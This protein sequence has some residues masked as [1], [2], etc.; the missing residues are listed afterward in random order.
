LLA[1]GCESGTV[2]FWPKDELA[3]IRSG[4]G[5]PEVFQA[6]QGQITALA[7]GGALLA[8]AGTDH[9][10]SLWDVTSVAAKHTLAAGGVTRA[11]ALSA[12]GKI[13]ATA[14]DEL[15][16]TLWDTVTGQAIGKLEGH[17]DW[18]LAMA[19]TAEGG[20]LLSG[21]Y[22]GVVR[23]W[24]VA[25]RKK[26][27]DGTVTAPPAP[28]TPPSAPVP[29]HAL[30]LSQDG[31]TLAVGCFDARIHLVN[32]A[33]GKLARSLGGHASAVTGLA[34]I[35]DFLVTGS[36]DATVRVWSLASGQVVKSLDGNAAWVLGVAAAGNSAVSIGADRAVRVWP[37][38]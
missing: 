27:L 15:A 30:A 8:T 1:V 28:N 18:V 4:S 19:F 5:S 26:I 22:D 7:W 36:R 34:F 20:R 9:K 6:H 24:D 13:L 17:T 11:L 33:D 25:A 35:D 37:F 3:G 10:V 16:I 29:I 2:Y 23:I 14:G 21:G 32:P 31:K 12:D 38:R